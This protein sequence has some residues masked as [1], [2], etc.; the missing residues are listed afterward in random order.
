MILTLDIIR[1]RCEEIGDCWIW[2]HGCTNTGGPNVRHGAKSV[3][4]RRLVLD[5]AGR[6]A[7]KGTFV[8]APKCLDRLC[9]NPDHLQALKPKPYAAFMNKHGFVNTL[10]HKAAQIAANRSRAKLSMEKAAE[11]RE[12]IAAGEPAASIAA[13][14][15]ISRE[16][17]NR[18]ARGGNWQP[19]VAGASVFS[20]A[21]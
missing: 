2:R 20:L 5:L 15:H 3:M 18:V 10:A 21:G 8:V 13:D 12:R 17:V 19:L 4:V 11:L 7:P 6:P 1:G 14:L 9:C 16:H